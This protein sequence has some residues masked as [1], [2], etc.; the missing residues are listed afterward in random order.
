MEMTT[1]PSVGAKFVASSPVAASSSAAPG[2]ARPSMVV[3]G[4]GIQLVPSSERASART[5]PE[6]CGRNVVS[7]RARVLAHGREPRCHAVAEATE[8]AADVQPVARVG[9]ERA[10]EVVARAGRPMRVGRSGD[11]ETAASRLRVW[12]P[13]VVNPPPRRP[14]S[15]PRM[16][17]NA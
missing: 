13:T 2:R 11:R 8:A 10:N 16:R 12:P 6:A 17:P 15:R 1:P 3:K 5:V 14:W 7:D 4:H 9:G